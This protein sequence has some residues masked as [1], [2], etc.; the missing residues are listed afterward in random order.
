MYGKPVF[1]YRYRE[2]FGGGGGAH[3]GSG[4]HIW[5]IGITD[6]NK[7]QEVNDP[8]YSASEKQPDA[9]FDSSPSSA[10]G[11]CAR[12]PAS[13]SCT[14]R[15]CK[16]GRCHPYHK[17]KGK[18]TRWYGGGASLKVVAAAKSG[19]SFDCLLQFRPR[20]HD[21]DDVRTY[22]PNACRP[23]AADAASADGLAQHLH[24]QGD[25]PVHQRI[26]QPQGYRWRVQEDDRDVRHLT[27][28]CS[29]CVCLSLSLSMYPGFL[30][31]I[32]YYSTSCCDPFCS[33]YAAT[34]RMRMPHVDTD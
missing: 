9:L 23:A 3:G 6:Y 2:G 21:D 16:D 33:T 5:V 10:E 11:G 32:S 28:H 29:L 8:D 1:L 13:P 4:R 12:N 18:Y 26:S 31:I 14:W 15:E 22:M 20:L 24:L 30:T 7:P 19:G 27:P 34:D 17:S 25:S